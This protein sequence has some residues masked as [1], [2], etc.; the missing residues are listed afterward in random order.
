MT[1]KKRAHNLLFLY[2]FLVIIPT[3]PHFETLE[4]L[5]S[6]AQAYKEDVK[7]DNNNP[8]YPDFTSAYKQEKGNYFKRIKDYFFGISH[9][10]FDPYGFKKLLEEVTHVREQKKFTKLHE[11]TIALPPQATIV[12]WGSLYGSY[13]SLV[14]T[15]TELYN[16]KIINNNLEIIKEQCYFAFL[17]DVINRS[18]YS[19]VT[20]TIILTLMKKNPDKVIYIKGQQERN[21]YWENFTVRLSLK[22]FSSDFLKPEDH[23]IPLSSVLNTFFATLPDR[24]IVHRDP[25]EKDQAFYASHAM[26]EEDIIRRNELEVLLLGTRNF[27]ND[28]KSGLEFI[29]YN[30]GTATWSL[31]SCPNTL[32]QEFYKFYYDSFAIFEMGEKVLNSIITVFDQDARTKNGFSKKSFDVLYAIPI[33]DKNDIKKIHA[34]RPFEVGSTMPLSGGEGNV[35]RTVS[36]GLNA[37]MYNFNRTH[38]S[39]AHFFIR[40]N[41]FD[42]QLIPR[43]AR[44]NIKMLHDDYKT[45][46]FLL[47]VGTPTLA[48]YLPT[49]EKENMF[50]FFPVTGTVL[51][52]NP[53][54]KNIINLRAAYSDEVHALIDYIITEYRSKRFAFFY[55]DDVYGKDA[56]EAAHNE[57]TKRG[58]TNWTDIS[59]TLEE[60][61]FK[62][63]VQKLKDA[64][65]DAIGFFSNS[66]PSQ[67]F[68]DQVG[69]DFFVGLNLFCISFVESASLRFFLNQ[70]GIPFTFSSVMPN[71]TTNNLPI[72]KE[73]HDAM[74]RLNIQYSS[75]SLE[76]YIATEL[77]LDALIHVKPPILCEGITC[78]VAPQ[79]K[80][81]IMKYLESL[82]NYNF[83]GLNLTFNPQT[84]S[85]DLPVWIETEEGEWI[86]YDTK[87][88]LRIATQ[89]ATPGMPAT[90]KTELQPGSK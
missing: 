48:T 81:A 66:A 33:K 25:E 70:Q 42:D 72:F 62:A 53:V 5:Q 13:H 1:Y 60:T 29:G 38:A 65:P 43:L 6:Y 36:S 68:I 19:L 89:L 51:S 55:Q 76:A 82:K 30:H 80:G 75:D 45:D 73:Y 86:E 56:L 3:L 7:S 59:Y 35:G 2:F 49:L 58:I 47:P 39:D 22:T 41:I 14:R 27:G 9:E 10:I 44:V 20:L 40:N 17:G 46:Y 69:T 79:A 4:A 74:D 12:F 54:L 67:Q 64:N 18:P 11:Q 34:Q 50:V 85:F 16:K 52:R 61:D 88:R 63:Q 90:L 32:N 15:L 8:E 23:A 24:L 78:K 83:K 26:P 77:F 84:R 71:P 87:T 57:L 28:I 37:S 21:R 31:L